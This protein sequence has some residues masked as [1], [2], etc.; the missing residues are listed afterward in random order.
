MKYSVRHSSKKTGSWKGLFGIEQ[1]RRYSVSNL[2]SDSTSDFAP[3][4]NCVWR[5]DFGSLRYSL[6]QITED[7]GWDERAVHNVNVTFRCVLLLIFSG[8]SPSTL[9]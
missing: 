4:A 9:G 8:Y 3:W 5:V 7:K 1:S 2:K 6:H